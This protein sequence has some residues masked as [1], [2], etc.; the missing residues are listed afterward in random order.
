MKKTDRYPE[1]LSEQ[2]EQ[3]ILSIRNAPVPVVPQEEIEAVCK[4]AISYYTEKQSIWEE[5]FWKV[6]FSCF[7]TGSAF[8]WLLSAFLLGSLVVISLLGA[9]NV[10]P[11]SLMTVLAP[12]PMLAYVIRELQ[13]RDENLTLLEKA[14]KYD[15]S[16]IYFARLWL[17]MIANALFVLLTGLIVFSHYEKLLQLYF[18]AF[19]AMFLIG[20]AA[21]FCMAFSDSALPL[22]LIMAVWVL[23]AS[24]LLCRSEVSEF[25]LNAGTGTLI[26][27]MLFGFGL[28][29]AAARKSTAKLYA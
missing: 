11:V 18:C 20:A 6:V 2:E 8:F 17:G 29:A 23:G 16:K 3:I 7:T 4:T 12:V 10:L 5:S 14:C 1:K 28:F 19:T 15:P 26:T 24:Y 22:S 21:L 25:I 9:E 13:Y 27:G